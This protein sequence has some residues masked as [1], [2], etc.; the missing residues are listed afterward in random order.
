[1]RQPRGE[2]EDQEGADHGHD[3]EEQRDHGRHERAEQHEQDEER[4]DEADDVADALLRWRAL[5]FAGEL[6]L[7]PRRVAYLSQLVLERDDVR[8]LELEAGLVELD[9]EESNVAVI[10]KL[11][12]VG[13]ERVRDVGDVRRILGELLL[14]RLGGEEHL[15]DRGLIERL[16]VLGRH[17][18][19]KR[20]TLVATELLGDQVGRLLGVGARNLEV[21]D[22]LAVE[23]NVQSDQTGR[24]R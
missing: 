12:R 21:V 14:R 4:R 13:C 24:M 20:R 3:R 18:H 10:R 8:T 7:D 23:R 16:P 6:R 22:Q 2:E 11:A 15:L 5:G 1:M 9:V 19:P 17:H